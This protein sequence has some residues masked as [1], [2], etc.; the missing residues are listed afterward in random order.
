M[1][2]SF[3]APILALGIATTALTG[4][5]PALAASPDRT[6]A[7]ETQRSQAGLITSLT[8]F[9]YALISGKHVRIDRYAT[10]P[11]LAGAPAR[12]ALNL[13]P[14]AQRRPSSF[15]FRITRVSG[16][17]GAATMQLK[18]GA[19]VGTTR[20]LWTYTGAGWKLSALGQRGVIPAGLELARYA[21]VNGKVSAQ[22]IGKS[23][24]PNEQVQVTYRV[25]VRDVFT[26]QF[27]A[28]ATADRFGAFLL[29][30]KFDLGNP[31]YGYTITA[32]AVGE[33][34]DRATFNTWASGQVR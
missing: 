21:P 27:Q 17:T 28:T 34:G 3:T 30:V 11:L 23:F 18:Q 19:S 10:R 20:T 15:T 22:M 33:T 13:L 5:V 29:S 31:G 14:Q 16:S 7:R 24:V 8:N 9:G 25:T 2:R 1:F 12:H 32:T 26:R 4:T 6:P